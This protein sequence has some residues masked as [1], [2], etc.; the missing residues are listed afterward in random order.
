MGAAPASSSIDAYG[1]L[2]KNVCSQ[3]ITNHASVRVETCI[4]HLKTQDD[5]VALCFNS[6]ASL[7]FHTL[8]INRNA[9]CV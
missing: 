4:N 2:L 6:S 8:F 7:F 9:P 3:I 5:I 1:L